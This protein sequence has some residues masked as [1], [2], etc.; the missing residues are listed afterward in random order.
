MDYFL[1]IP[2]CYCLFCIIMSVVYFFYTVEKP[3]C[4]DNSE[5]ESEYQE[6]YKKEQEI[7]ESLCDE[8]Y[9][10]RKSNKVCSCALTL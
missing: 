8:K 10:M 5:K 7:L 1:L 4:E 6:K 9:N 2:I 3:I